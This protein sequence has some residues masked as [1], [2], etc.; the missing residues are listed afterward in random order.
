[1]IP[2]GVA[3]ISGYAHIALRSYGEN[4]AR[5]YFSDTID[6]PGQHL[7]R[8]WSLKTQEYPFA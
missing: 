5:T 8:L 4:G 1:M 6:D 7:R 3:R 2:D